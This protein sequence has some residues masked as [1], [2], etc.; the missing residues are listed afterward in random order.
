MQW[1]LHNGAA[2]SVVVQ[3]DAFEEFPWVQDEDNELRTMTVHQEK[4]FRS[5]AAQ[6]V[7]RAS[8]GIPGHARAS[9]GTP[10][11]PRA[12]QGSQ[13]IKVP[14][15]PSGQS[16]HLVGI[17]GCSGMPWDALGSSEGP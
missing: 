11:H 10:G 8:L 12:R 14:G 16:L 1:E 6:G 4:P 2:T 15:K 5:P 13:G 7:P 3:N 9:Q 17:L